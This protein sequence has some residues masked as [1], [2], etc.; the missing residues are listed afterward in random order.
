MADNTFKRGPQ[1]KLA[2]SE[3]EFRFDL[4]SEPKTAPIVVPGC[5][6][7]NVVYVNAN[8]KRPV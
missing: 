7:D 5:P 3:D 4:R 2:V 6:S 8:L 1:P